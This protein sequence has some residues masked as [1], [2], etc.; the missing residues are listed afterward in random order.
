[1]RDSLYSIIALVLVGG[2]ML[3]TFPLLGALIRSSTGMIDLLLWLLAKLLRPAISRWHPTVPY[4]PEISL[5]SQFFVGLIFFYYFIYQVENQQERLSTFEMILLFSFLVLLLPLWAA[6]IV[7]QATHYRKHFSE[8]LFYH[9]FIK[10][11]WDWVTYQSYAL[12][13]LQQLP[14]LEPVIGAL[15]EV[16]SRVKHRRWQTFLRS[17]FF[18][19][20]FTLP[21]TLLPASVYAWL[22]SIA[23]SF[24]E[25]IPLLQEYM[26]ISWFHEP[27]T[28]LGALYLYLFDW[29]ATVIVLYLVVCVLAP[30]EPRNLFESVAE[31]LQYF[32]K[33]RRI[34]VF[35]SYF[36]HNSLVEH[37]PTSCSLYSDD[38][39]L[40]WEQLALA[41]HKTTVELDEFMPLTG[42]GI[43]S[44]VALVFE[45]RAEQESEVRHAHCIH[46]R[47]FGATAFLVAVDA[48]E[49][50]FN[51]DIR[52]QSNFQQLTESVGSLINI[53]HSLR[54]SS[55]QTSDNITRK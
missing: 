37:V 14:L 35:T 17:L 28:I 27:L 25:N 46:Y 50:L 49:D 7:W 3:G 41:L 6:L 16:A 53:R 42:Q 12:L 26:N 47:R 55:G 39:P 29:V 31:A 19:S 45:D 2:L 51:D 1:M 44:R 36:W 20:L 21:V 9:R 54:Y 48:H 15:D 18:L 23:R 13:W 30:L 40:P 38:Q 52:S 32:V 43:N 33:D 8:I 22:G 11:M 34:F 24:P 10:P 4:L 5:G